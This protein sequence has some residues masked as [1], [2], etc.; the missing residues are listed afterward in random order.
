M[1]LPLLRDW[2]WLQ[3]SQWLDTNELTRVQ[4][5]MLTA[6]VT[7]AFQNVPFYHKLYGAAGVD[8]NDISTSTINKLPIITKQQ[9]RDVPLSE[10]TSVKINPSTCFTRTTSGSTG[11]PV[12]VLEE[13]RGS[14]QGS[15]LVEAFLDLWC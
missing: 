6:I 9:V 2:L 10:R 1:L 5:K 4:D 12:T 15:A 14:P 8:P 13:P 3:R 11:I 7:H